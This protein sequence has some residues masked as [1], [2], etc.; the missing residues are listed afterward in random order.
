VPLDA[1][2][3]EPVAA[4][5]GNVDAVDAAVGNEHVHATD[6]MGVVLAWGRLTIRDDLETRLETL[7]I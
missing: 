4:A 3:V 2:R 5:I 7:R 1:R 6:V